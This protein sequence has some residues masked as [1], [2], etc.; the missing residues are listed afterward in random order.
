MCP[1]I[2][3]RGERVKTVTKLSIVIFIYLRVELR[4]G[5]SVCF[6]SPLAYKKKVFMFVTDRMEETFENDA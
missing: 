2:S 5:S 3:L 6:I 4:K 1:V